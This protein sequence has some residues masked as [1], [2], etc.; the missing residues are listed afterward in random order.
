VKLMIPI[1]NSE[2]WTIARIDDRK[3]LYRKT[4]YWNTKKAIYLLFTLSSDLPNEIKII[5]YE[6][7]WNTTDIPQIIEFLKPI[8]ISYENYISQPYIEN[9]KDFRFRLTNIHVPEN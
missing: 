3:S 8:E 2:P 7:P 6:N 9:K 5:L 1:P 4:K